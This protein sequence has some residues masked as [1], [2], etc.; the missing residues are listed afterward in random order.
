MAQTCRQRTG[1]GGVFWHFANDSSFAGNM[2]PH[3]LIRCFSVLVSAQKGRLLIHR[4]V[5]MRF[6]MEGKEREEEW[7][8]RKGGF[9]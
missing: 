4:L 1:K 7:E 6:L 3:D 2:T 5:T 8:V 9:C